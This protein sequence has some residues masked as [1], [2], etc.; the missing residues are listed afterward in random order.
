MGVWE[1][2]LSTERQTSASMLDRQVDTERMTA[3][4]E[5]EMVQH[6]PVA[7]SMTHSSLFDVHWWR[8]PE[9]ELD[10]SPWHDAAWMDNG[11]DRSRA[12]AAERKFIVDVVLV[13]VVIVLLLCSHE[14]DDRVQPLP[15][16][17]SCKIGCCE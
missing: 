8:R 6:D 13:C 4:V 2:E 16:K 12:A 9:Q 11:A 17:C 15:L 10:A 7:V 5:E 3:V 1:F 14:C